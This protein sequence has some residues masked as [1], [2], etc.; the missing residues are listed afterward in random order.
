MVKKKQAS[1]KKPTPVKA[2]NTDQKTIDRISS[3]VFLERLKTEIDIIYGHIENIENARG[4]IE[5]FGKDLII[6]LRDLSEL[7]PS[8]E[9]NLED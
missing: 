1:K 9:E 3:S 5:D 4:E 8:E 6:D 2:H 7:I